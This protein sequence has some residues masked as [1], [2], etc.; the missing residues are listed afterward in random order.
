MKS[1][2]FSSSTYTVNPNP[3]PSPRALRSC[4]YKGYHGRQLLGMRA[5]GFRGVELSVL[6]SRDY[7][8]FRD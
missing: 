3:N 1:L 8:G 6:F 5:L 7:I 2:G 4:Q